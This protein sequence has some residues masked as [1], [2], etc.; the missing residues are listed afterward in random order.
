VGSVTVVSWNVNS[1]NARLDRVLGFLRRENP[2]Y[3]CLQELKCPD[4]KFPFEAIKGL[5]YHATVFGQKSYNGVA[6][7]SK[8]PVTIHSKNFGDGDAD[9]SARF[10]AVSTGSFTLMNAYVPNGQSLD[11][12]K[13]PYK[14]DWLKRARNFLDKD[15]RPTDRIV[16]V[17]DFNIAPDDRDV[18]DP[19]A[20]RNHI[21][22]TPPEREALAKLVSYGFVDTLRMFHQGDKLFS[23]WDYREGS[24]PQNKGLRI[25]LIYATPTMAMACREV[26]IDKAE[27]EG[28]KP[29]D[30]APVI[31]TFSM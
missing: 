25:D 22:C 14:L 5:G 19:T 2:D 15:F 24:F 16:L 28:E 13:Y 21:H 7:L 12:P 9:E 6:I 18:Y 23:W 1:V 26:R 20:W 4:E 30:H 10:I 29:S 3:V 17:G 27:R 11:S 8:Q 31:A